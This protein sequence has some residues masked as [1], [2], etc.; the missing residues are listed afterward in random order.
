MSLTGQDVINYAV[1]RSALNFPAQAGVAA[2]LSLISTEQRKIYLIAE[3]IDPEYF[4][5]NS[6]TAARAL[7]TDSW[8]LDATPGDVGGV[9]KAT[10]AAITGSPVNPETN[11]TFA[12]GDVI[13]LV[14]SRF[15][16]LELGPRAYVRGRKIV[17]HLTELGAASNAMVT[18]LTVYYSP[19]PPFVTQVGTTLA[20]PDEWRHLLVL[21]V[22]RMLAIRDKRE[23][24]VQFIE[25]EYKDALANFQEAVLA[26]AHGARRPLPAVSAVPQTGITRKG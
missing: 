20:V 24:E 3:R 12:V 18:Q 23:E 5:K 14:N 2:A 6:L 11:T 8:D 15:P 22:A 21:P 25:A 10:V 19:I 17:P 16:E 26:Y 13:H 7:Y 9:T 1:D 4:G